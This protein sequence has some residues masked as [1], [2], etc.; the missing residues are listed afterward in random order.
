MKNT[1]ILVIFFLASSFLLGA[2]YIIPPEY[3]NLINSAESSQKVL[4]SNGSSIGGQTRSIG[5][6]SVRYKCVTLPKI[7]C[8]GSSATMSISISEVSLRDTTNKLVTTFA[9]D[10]YVENGTGGNSWNVCGGAVGGMLWDDSTLVATKIGN[11]T[12]LT[13]SYTPNANQLIYHFFTNLG[14]SGGNGSYMTIYTKQF[15][16]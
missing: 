4:I 14:S 15:C 3:D 7:L 16:Q 13:Y 6:R 2:E 11:D 8:R 9:T 12:R 1:K 5:G 10:A